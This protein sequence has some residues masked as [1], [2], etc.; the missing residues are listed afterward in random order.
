[1]RLQSEWDVLRK[2]V[3][4]IRAELPRMNM[5]KRTIVQGPGES[6]QMPQEQNH[7]HF[8][9]KE[10]DAVIRYTPLSPIFGSLI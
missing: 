6:S 8:Y 7:G 4:G 1:M 3:Q 10:E 5:Y 9:G 2:N